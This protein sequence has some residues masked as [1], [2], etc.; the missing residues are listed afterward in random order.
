MAIGAL[1]LISVGLTAV[2]TAVSMY[3][4]I[5]Q[6]KA[7]EDAAKF[8]AAVARNNAIAARNQV[9]FEN[10]RIRDRQARLRGT[11]IATGLKQGRTYSGSLLDVIY[12][13]ELEAELDI[14]ANV[15]RGQVAAGNQLA[16][17]E[18]SR[19]EA[20]S[21]RSSGRLRAAST[22]L[23]GAGMAASTISSNLPTYASRSNPLIE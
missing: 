7:Q 23:T 10:Q 18:L 4:S 16:Q 12:D 9:D 20:R 19:F 17:A 3:G 1:G 22:L 6:A 14:L 21:A 8:N 15:Y 11:Q 13:S 2:G 5:Q